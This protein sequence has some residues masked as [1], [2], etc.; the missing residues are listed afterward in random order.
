MAAKQA[1]RRFALRRR[2]K[3]D[4][5]LQKELR[6]RRRRGGRQLLAFHTDGGGGVSRLVAAKAAQAGLCVGPGGEGGE[7]REEAG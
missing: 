2:L 5:E 4:E 1:W 7:E 3:N 6:G